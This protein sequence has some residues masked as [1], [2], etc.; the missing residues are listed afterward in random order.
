MLIYRLQNTLN[1]TQ[2]L[3]WQ[4]LVKQTLGENVH[5]SRQRG[6]CLAREALRDCFKAYNLPLEIND[7]QMVHFDAL[8]TYPDYTL[9]LSHSSEWGAALVGERSRYVSV[10]IDIEPLSRIVKPLILERIA[11]SRDHSYSPLETWALKEASFKAIMNTRRFEKPIEFSSIRLLDQGWS[12]STGLSGPSII[13]TNSGQL[14][15]RSWLE[16]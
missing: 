8:K 6:F 9:S 10:G 16:K 3:Q 13:E 2:E 4:E 5:H 15:A 1:F 12:H 11:H 7:L 14:V